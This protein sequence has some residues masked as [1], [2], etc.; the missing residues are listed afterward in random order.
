M[1]TE[2]Q[3]ELIHREIDGENTPEA[4]AEAR[5]LVASQ[6]EAL[7]LMTNLQSL[8]ALFRDVPDREPPPMSLNP[9]ASPRAGQVQGAT[10]TINRWATQQWNGISNFMGELMLTKKVLLGATTAVAAIAIIGYAIVG[11]PP[12]V[13]DSCTIG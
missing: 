13:N 5:E 2:Y 6:P 4:S 9:R 3:I 1:L 8:D 7:T 10:Q 11:Y 12:S